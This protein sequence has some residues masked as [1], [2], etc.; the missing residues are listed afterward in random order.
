MPKIWVPIILGKGG[1]GELFF[2]L[3][4]T[5]LFIFTD[6]VESCTEIERNLGQIKTFL[7]ELSIPF[8]KLY[9]FAQ[10]FEFSE[11]M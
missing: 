6:Y 2:A 7:Q 4:K 3:N 9:F 11:K 5:I 1:L 8:R 10:K